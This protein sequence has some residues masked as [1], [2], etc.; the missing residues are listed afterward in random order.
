MR[1]GWGSRRR[2]RK[3]AVA[4]VALT[5]LP[6]AVL[7]AAHVSASNAG[8]AV[9]RSG[10]GTLD[11][12]LPS[13]DALQRSQASNL[14]AP[15]AWDG[16]TA[17]GPFV[18]FDFAPATGTVVGM[19]AVNGSQTELL[20][21]SVRID[22]FS[23]VSAP[24]VSGATFTAVGSTVLLVAHDE[25]TA[26]VQITTTT[27]P[28]TIE[29]NFPETTMNLEVSHATAWPHAALSF[30]IGNTTGRIIV[31][32]GTLAVNGTSVTAELE[33]YDSLAFRAVP[34][35]MEDRAERTA[36]LDAFASG[37]LAAEYGLV[38]MTNG[39]Y[40]QNAV[41]Y[42]PTLSMSNGGVAFN[43]ATISLDAAP[44]QDGLVLIAFDPR[45]MPADAAHRIVVTAD[46]VGVPESTNPLSSLYAGAG[47]SGPA[48]FTRL[49]MNAT[50][51]VI[52]LPSL[53]TSVLQV[54]SL[55]LGLAGPDVGTQLAM[56]AA[57]F[58]VSLAAAVMFRTRRE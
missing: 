26:L 35:F 22:G 56:V 52:Y 43:K 18:T 2:L 12:D 57:V 13:V 34:S 29:F 27:E 8:T 44:S 21:D 55:P 33:S 10:I 20:V 58:V 24:Q 19:F 1:N 9:S 14:F 39:A 17:S 49:S 40:L 23:P 6:V 25:P 37:R 30:T 11:L 7:V 54:E 53:T 3:A 5:L 38:A 50:A 46:G 15:F 31:G 42:N 36:L 16:H 51:L 4:L 45:T 41:Q 32:R 48:S 28:R 47:S